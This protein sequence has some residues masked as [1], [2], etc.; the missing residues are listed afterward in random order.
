MYYTYLLRCQDDSIYTGIT[1]D[2]SRRM[3]EHFSQGKRCARYTMIHPAKRLEGVWQ[4]ENRSLASRLEFQIK[5]LS[6]ADKE[7]LLH[8][9]RLE[10]YLGGKVTPTDYQPLD[11]QTITQINEAIGGK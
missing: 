7:A 10:R 4:S 3:Q 11:A 8:T 2:L 6:K 9:G 5:R 1:T